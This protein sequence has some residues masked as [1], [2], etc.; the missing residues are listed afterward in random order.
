M[1]RLLRISTMADAGIALTVPVCEQGDG[2]GPR[3][4]R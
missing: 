1:I 3:R 2:S 4:D